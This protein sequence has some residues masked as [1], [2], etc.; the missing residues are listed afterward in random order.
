LLWTGYCNTA[1][2]YGLLWTGYWNMTISD[3]CCEQDIGTWRS[4]KGCCEQNIGT[5]RSVNVCC[6]PDIGTWHSVIGCCK[7]DIGP[8]LRNKRQGMCW[9]YRTTVNLSRRAVFCEFVCYLPHII[10]VAVKISAPVS[11]WKHEKDVSGQLQ[12]S[13]T[14]LPLRDSL[15]QGLSG[16]IAGETSVMTLPWLEGPIV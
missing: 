5:W 3:G 13:S 10:P 2:S 14:L 7:Q 15:T 1:V 6:K 9:K 11:P 8:V 4:V 16:H 12:A